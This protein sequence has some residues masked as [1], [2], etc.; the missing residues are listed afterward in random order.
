[1]RLD[2]HEIGPFLEQLE[3][4]AE[5]IIKEISQLALYAN[6]GYQEVWNMSHKEREILINALSDKLKAEAGKPAENQL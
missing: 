3:K 5:A 2:D 4:D 1:L 6:I